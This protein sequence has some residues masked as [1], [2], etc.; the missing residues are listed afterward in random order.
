MVSGK[1]VS[2]CLHAKLK[3]NTNITPSLNY[4]FFF[5]RTD[6]IH[7]L[8][9]YELW[10]QNRFRHYLLHGLF[11][12]IFNG[13]QKYTIPHLTNNSTDYGWKVSVY[14]C[15]AAWNTVHKIVTQLLN[16]CTAYDTVPK[17]YSHGITL[18]VIYMT[19]YSFPAARNMIQ[20]PPPS[21]TNY[22]CR[23]CVN[24]WKGCNKQTLYRVKCAI[25]LVRRLSLWGEK[26][27]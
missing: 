19:L 26:D 25:T 13:Y 22:S 1:R 21:Q 6:L 4:F 2:I 3:V 15:V 17:S 24:D 16:Y 14:F 10:H 23:L 12:L 7:G 20:K 5:Y 8:Y 27:N 11:P 9:I 18:I